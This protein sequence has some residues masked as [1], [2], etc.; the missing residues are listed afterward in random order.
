MSLTNSAGTKLEIVAGAPAT[1]DIAG[2]G[3]LTYAEVGEIETMGAIGAVVQIGTFNSITKK[4]TDKY[5]GA[6]DPGDMSLGLARDAADV[7]QAVFDAA[8]GNG[9]HSV[10]LTDSNGLIVYFTCLVGSYTTNYGDINSVV[11]AEV[12]LALKILPVAGQ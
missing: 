11:K 8:I 12:N 7:G 2:F 10:K 3:A 5:E 4:V 6:I 1:E 9:V